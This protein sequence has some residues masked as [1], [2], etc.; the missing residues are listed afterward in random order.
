MNQS[1]PQSD[2]QDHVLSI[3][4]MVPV[5]KVWDEITKT[6]R[7]QKALY[8]TVLESA[9]QPGAKLR[10]YSP[11]RKRVFIVGEIVE[12]SPP[13]RLVHT[14]MMTQRPETPSL[15]TWELAPIDGGCRVT[16]THAGWTN[17]AT[18][19]KGVVGGWKQILGLLKADLET[20]RLPFGTRV[21]YA[22]MGRMMF[23]LPKSTKTEEVEKAG[24]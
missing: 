2:L 7:I 15:V 9:M 16:L 22:L 12:F 21:M 19:H 11:D 6:G 8:N 23:M 5:Q 3:D 13:T 4:I 14:Y 10:Y 24:W 17:Q 1:N 18:T 20:G